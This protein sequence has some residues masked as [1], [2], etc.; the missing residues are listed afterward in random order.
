MGIIENFVKLFGIKEES[1]NFSNF[2]R[3]LCHFSVKMTRT[4]QTR[5]PKGRGKPMLP[6]RLRR[7]AQKQAPFDIVL[8]VPNFPRLKNPENKDNS[9]F[10][11]ALMKR[12]QELTP[13]QEDQTLLTDFVNKIQ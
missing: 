7:E 11:E 1:K 4:K 8:D 6:P 2:S 10:S 5:R 13:S 3:D 12:I 9:F